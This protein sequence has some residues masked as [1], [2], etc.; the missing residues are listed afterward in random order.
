MQSLQVISKQ[1]NPRPRDYPWSTSGS[2]YFPESISISKPWLKLIL[3]FQTADPSKIK[4]IW[5]TVCWDASPWFLICGTGMSRLSCFFNKCTFEGLGFQPSINAFDLAQR[6]HF[7]SSPLR[8]YSG[9]AQGP[10]LGMNGLQTLLIR[11][12]E[13]KPFDHEPGRRI[14]H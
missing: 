10:L 1:A 4:F 3:C 8:Q 9:Q 6:E 13:S 14:P 12:W 11:Q 7:D 2:K 5:A